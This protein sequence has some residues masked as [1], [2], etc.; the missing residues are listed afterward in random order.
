MKSVAVGTILLLCAGFVNAG[1]AVKPAA[2]DDAIYKSKC[3]SC[4][5]KDAKGNAKLAKMLN[6][7]DPAVMDL[8][9]TTKTDAELAAVILAGRNKMPSFKGKLKDAEITAVLGYVR[10]LAPAPKAPVVEKKKG[11]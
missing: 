4:H 2:G 10:S 1:D 9:L 7:K 6:V 11:A 3:V 5:G 8:T